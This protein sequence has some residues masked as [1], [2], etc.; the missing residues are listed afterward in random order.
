MNYLKK[1]IG[2]KNKNLKNLLELFLTLQHTKELPRQG[3]YTHG[4]KLNDA[5]SVAA[6][7]FSVASMSFLMALELKKNGVKID[8]SKV[9]KM[10]L[11]HDYGEA[12]IG[13]I[14]R[15]VKIFAGGKIQEI[16]DKA[17]HA[18]IKKNSFKDD[19]I[20]LQQEYEERKSLEAILVKG[21]DF[22]DAIAQATS[23]KGADIKAFKDESKEFFKTFRK[24]NN[25]ISNL[26]EKSTKLLFEKKVKPYRGHREDQ[27]LM[28]H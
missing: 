1:K 9:I 7:S 4:F 16:E 14:G 13:D 26:I 12:I 11:I 15:L 3:F 28:L 5:D 6:H 25:E 23:V 8:E 27:K 17:F 24:K 19:L 10:G 20:Q 2:I 22:L 21:C 18:L